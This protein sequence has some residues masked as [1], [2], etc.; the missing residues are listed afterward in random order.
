MLRSEISYPFYPLNKFPELY[1]LKDS[2][3][4]IRDEALE[5]VDSFYPMNDGRNLTDNWTCM[6]LSP[7][8][9]DIEYHGIEL[10]NK[11]NKWSDKFSKTRELC[12][13]IEN[14]GYVFSLLGP[15][16]HIKTHDHEL[17]FVSAILGLDLEEPC[18]FRVGDQYVCIKE[19]QFTVFDY[20]VDHEAWNYSDR[21]RLVLLISLVNKYQ[22]S[23][24]SRSSSNILP[25]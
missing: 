10:M 15:K 13:S 14:V 7:E 16:G 3:E 20:T 12:N 18:L 24:N 11:V 9:D 17:N 5:Y 4:I 8:P 22:K 6:P 21:N 23:A 19:G 25:T 2:W 1:I